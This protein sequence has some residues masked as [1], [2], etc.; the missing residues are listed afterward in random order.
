MS[1][2]EKQKKIAL[3]EATLREILRL[4]KIASTDLTA[5]AFDDIFDGGRNEQE[6]K[7]IRRRAARLV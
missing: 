6:W 1:D 5:I 4:E 3:L 7:N 2:L